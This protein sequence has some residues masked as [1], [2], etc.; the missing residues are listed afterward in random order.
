VNASAASLADFIIDRL[1]RRGVR[2][3]FGVPGGGSS[4]DLIDA[5]ARAGIDFVLTR[6]ETAAAFMAAVTA[7]LTG[8]P[9]VVI[10]GIGP[11]AA[12]AVNGIAYAALEKAPVVLFSDCHESEATLHQAFDQQALY[13]PL[14]KGS[15]RLKPENADEFDALVDLAL[16]RPYGPVHIDLSAA[17]GAG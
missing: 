1:S 13:R 2:R 17:P 10:T 6:T 16:T 11:G 8:T 9:G 15:C 5:G 3:M 14:V 4:L 12:S 7:E